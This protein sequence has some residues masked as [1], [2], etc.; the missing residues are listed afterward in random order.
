MSHVN[1]VEAGILMKIIITQF[2][3]SLYV[4]MYVSMHPASIEF[5]NDSFHQTHIG[6]KITKISIEIL[7]P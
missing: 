6:K 4:S 1:T 2:N 5:T 3:R 7:L